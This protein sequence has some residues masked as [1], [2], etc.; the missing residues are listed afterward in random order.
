ME[1]K[2]ENQKEST[3]VDDDDDNTVYQKKEREKPVP[4]GAFAV[5]KSDEFVQAWNS[6]EYD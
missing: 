2:P 4:G 5:P 3:E 6:I 1:R